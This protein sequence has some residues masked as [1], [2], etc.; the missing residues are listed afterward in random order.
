MCERCCRRTE[1]TKRLTIQRFPRVIVLP[2]K[3]L[4]QWSDLNRFAMSRYSISKSTVSVSFP[5]TRLDLGPYGPPGID[6][7]GLRLCHMVTDVIT[8][9][10]GSVLYNLYAVCNHSGTVNMGH[11]TACCVD[12]SGWHCYNDASTQDMVS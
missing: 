10:R 2:R 4:T 9:C 11:Y 8:R 7:E 6:R 1:S 3:T 12:Q 5:L